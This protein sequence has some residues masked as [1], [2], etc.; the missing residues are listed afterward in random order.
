MLGINYRSI[1]SNSVGYKKDI[2]MRSMDFEEFLWAKGYDENFCSNMF[3]HMVKQT[4][5]S[6]T[7][8]S[9]LHS[10]FLDY[11]VLGGMP[12]VV[13]SFIEK[14]HLKVHLKFRDSFLKII[15]KIFVNMLTVW[16][17]Q[18]YLMFSTELHRSLQRKIRNFR[19]LRLLPE[20]VFAIIEAVWTGL[21]MPVS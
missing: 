11:S 14:I 4:P 15:R 10:L 13:S 8:L 20:R 2:I 16:I 7:E 5:F 1:E 3:E 21:Q 9:V 18:E 19:Y 6:E 12:A 17:R